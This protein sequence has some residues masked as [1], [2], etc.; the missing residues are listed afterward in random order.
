MRNRATMKIFN[1]TLQGLVTE[2]LTYEG[3]SA[4]ERWATLAGTQPPEILCEPRGTRLRLHQKRSLFGC[5]FVYA[6]RSCP[7]HRSENSWKSI[8]FEEHSEQV[9]WR[10]E[11][12]NCLYMLN[13]APDVIITTVRRTF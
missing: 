9:E 1:S 7:D 5:L 11:Y 13:R 2:S 10:E 4:I 12:V 6:E 8:K 3:Q